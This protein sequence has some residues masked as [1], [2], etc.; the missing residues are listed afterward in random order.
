M[1]GGAVYRAMMADPALARIPVLVST[2]TPERAPPGSV[3][4]PKPLKLKRLLAA[5]ERVF[6]TGAAG[7]TPPAAR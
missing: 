2:A 3:V 1:D 5:V 4:L 6:V 7:P